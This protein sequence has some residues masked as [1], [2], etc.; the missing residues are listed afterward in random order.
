L[1]KPIIDRVLKNN[2]WL[3]TIYPERLLRKFSILRARLLSVGGK[4][5]C[6]PI[7]FDGNDDDENINDSID[8]TETDLTHLLRFGLLFEGPVK[9]IRGKRHC[10]HDNVR[11]TWC[12]HKDKYDTA[13]GYTLAN[14][15]IW[16]QHSWLL[17]KEGNTIETTISNVLYYGYITTGDFLFTPKFQK[18]LYDYASEVKATA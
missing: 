18:R 7:I 6:L 5:I 2:D 4:E 1:T 17:D 10:C 14:N 8:A 15:K 9:K 12:S 11:E 13:S 3:I 16:W